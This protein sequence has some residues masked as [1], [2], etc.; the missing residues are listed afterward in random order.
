MKTWTSAQVPRKLELPNWDVSLSRSSGKLS[1]KDLDFREW[2][3][4]SVTM[5][6]T[7][8]SQRSRSCASATLNPKP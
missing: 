3:F 5:L 7:S 6:E 8:S 4:V 1:S 2:A